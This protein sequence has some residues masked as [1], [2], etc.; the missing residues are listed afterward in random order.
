MGTA[1]PLGSNGVP[2]V[3]EAVTVEGQIA[4]AQY[5]AAVEGIW[6]QGMLPKVSERHGQF[7]MDLVE[8]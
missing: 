4:E 3:L 8:S 6:N 1:S 7:P 2:Y 5:A